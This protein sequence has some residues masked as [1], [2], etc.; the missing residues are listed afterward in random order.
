MKARNFIV[1]VIA[2]ACC[3]LCSPVSSAQ[4][5]RPITVW[6]DTLTKGLCDGATFTIPVWIGDLKASD[7]VQGFQLAVRWDKAHIDLEFP[8]Y[9]ASSN[10]LASQAKDRAP[11]QIDPEGTS[12]VII[13]GNIDGTI[14]VGS[15][16]PLLYLTGRVK[17]PDTVGWLNGWIEPFSF[18]AEGLTNFEPI[19][20]RAGFVHV[21]QDT[22][23]AYTG[24]A[25]IDSGRFGIHDL[26]TVSLMVQ[27]VRDRRVSEINVT[28]RGDANYYKFVG[29]DETGTLSES[30]SW[31]VKSIDIGPDSIGLRYVS[32]AAISAQ[33][34][35]LKVVLKRATDSSF[36]R[37]LAIETF[38]VNPLSC[39]GKLTATGARV[40]AERIID[41][42][43]TRVVDLKGDEAGE[44]IRLLSV[45]DRALVIGAE[46]FRIDDVIVVDRVG[47][48][49]ATHSAG[50]AGSRSLTIDL[51][52]G[53]TSGVYFLV[54]RSGNDLVYKQFTFI[55]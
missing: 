20:Y 13:A 27:N 36:D 10:T 32:P 24:R 45:T 41:T 46:G 8:Y 40:T 34:T 42:A 19:T 44:K 53:L 48:V 51:D 22:T 21:R 54:I 18:R 52:G 35:L 25:T 33:G 2:A 7:S 49:V 55:K 28:V 14:I 16:K 4:S 37:P 47:R 17:A 30:V 3:C 29:V 5:P 1:F 9:V 31:S 38:Q 23:E 39:L 50:E 26:D 11:A 43:T 15:G 12:A 6:V